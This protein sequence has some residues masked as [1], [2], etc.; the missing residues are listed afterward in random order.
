MFVP[1]DKPRRRSWELMN[2]EQQ[3][4]WAQGKMCRPRSSRAPPL[5]DVQRWKH[6]KHGMLVKQYGMFNM[7]N[8][9]IHHQTER[10]FHDPESV[11]QDWDFGPLND[12]EILKF[13]PVLDDRSWW[14]CLLGN[15]KD[16]PWWSKCGGAAWGTWL[17]YGLPMWLA[18]GENGV[19]CPIFQ[20][21]DYIGMGHNGVPY[22]YTNPYPNMVMGQ[23]W[24]PR[25]P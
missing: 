21:L 7:G 4:C 9:G 18:I 2:S 23:T 8:M 20:W 24:R 6:G 14:G 12:S 22:F 19:P 17:L 3:G 10:F 25:G 13:Q 15:E 11:R 16:L 1:H 5:A